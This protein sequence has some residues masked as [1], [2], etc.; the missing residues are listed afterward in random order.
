[1]VMWGSC[2]NSTDPSGP[3]PMDS[4]GLGEAQASNIYQAL[5]ELVL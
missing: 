5:H 3:D 4:V 2:E 1:M